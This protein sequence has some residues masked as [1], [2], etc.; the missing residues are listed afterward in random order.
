MYVVILVIIIK[1]SFTQVAKPSTHT[2]I[3]SHFVKIKSPKHKKFQSSIIKVQ[4]GEDLSDNSS[5]KG[6]H[7]ENPLANKRDPRG[8]VQNTRLLVIFLITL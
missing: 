8:N 2:F 4:K 5:K 7:Q 1:S 6:K 3:Y